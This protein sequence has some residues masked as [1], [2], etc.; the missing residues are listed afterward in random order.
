MI[1]ERD[2]SAPRLGVGEPPAINCD[3]MRL[4]PVVDGDDQQPLWQNRRAHDSVGSLP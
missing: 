3:P 2:P 4:A 1:V